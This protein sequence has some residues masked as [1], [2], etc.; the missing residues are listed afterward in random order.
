MINGHTRLE[1]VQPR[2]IPGPVRLPV[3]FDITFT[4]QINKKNKV[5]SDGRMFISGAMQV[6]VLDSFNQLV[7]SCDLFAQKP[8]L[9]LFEKQYVRAVLDSQG[10]LQGVIDGV[11]VCLDNPPNLA[12]LGIS[13]SEINDYHRHEFVPASYFYGLKSIKTED[14]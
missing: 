5:F 7:G 4:R 11:I 14:N 10:L 13:F 1:S 2:P 12:Y 3:E 6:K 8:K 9:E